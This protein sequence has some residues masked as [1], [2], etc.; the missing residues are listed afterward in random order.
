MMWRRTWHYV[1]SLVPLVVNFVDTI[2]SPQLHQSIIW[3]SF[4]LLKPTPVV[5][6]WAVCIQIMCLAVKLLSYD[7]G[8]VHDRC[9]NPRHFSALYNICSIPICL[10]Y[11]SLKIYIQNISLK[12]HHVGRWF[13]SVHSHPITIHSPRDVLAFFPNMLHAL[14]PK[15]SWPGCLWIY[16]LIKYTYS[17]IT[18]L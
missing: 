17:A 2:M 14:P 6:H 11:A 18:V 1:K 13:P 16:F 12:N 5:F 7:K 4:P 10:Y 3:I 8:D 9:I 15:G